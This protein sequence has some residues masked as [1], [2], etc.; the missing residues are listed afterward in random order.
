VVM[1][2]RDQT[3]ERQRERALQESRE[4]YRLL[5]ENVSDVIWI[6]DLEDGRFTYVSPSVEKLRGYT[7]E[8]V[9]EQDMISALTAESLETLMAV[10]PERVDEYT[11]GIHKDYTDRIAQPKKDGGVVW[12]ECTTNYVRNLKTGHLEVYGVSRDITLRKEAEEEINRLKAELEQRVRQRTAQLE[13]V[14]RELESFNYSVSHDL[15]APLRHLTGFINLLERHS[16]QSPDEKSRH[17]MQVISEA[18]VT[19]GKLIDDLLSFSR[20]G[21]AEMTPKLVNMDKMLQEI[22]STVE[23]NLDQRNI[24]WTIHPLPEV[25]GDPLLLKTVRT[26][27]VLNAVKFTGRREQAMIEIGYQEDHGRE[28][29]FYIKDNGIGFDMTYQDKLFS[30]FQRLHQKEEFE[31]TGLGLANVRRIITRHGGKTW[32][33]GAVGEGATFYFTLP[34]R[35]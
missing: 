13:A 9:M 26:N 31:G 25:Q 11:H 5:A 2:F 15:R 29:I 18:A 27:L 17:Y 8:E 6:L 16:P 14:N 28:E 34:K 10:V 21:R 19:M 1:V 32:A 3:E 22:V 4:L 7:V 30:L 33:E 24:N 12:T 35:F 20:M 23:P